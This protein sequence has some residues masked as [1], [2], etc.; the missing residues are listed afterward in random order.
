MNTH[1]AQ[2]L[3]VIEWIV[4]AFMKQSRQAFAGVVAILTSTKGPEKPKC[5]EFCVSSVVV[6]DVSRCN[7]HGEIIGELPLLVNIFFD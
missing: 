7:L 6:G 2:R 3:E 4:F 1:F 5:L